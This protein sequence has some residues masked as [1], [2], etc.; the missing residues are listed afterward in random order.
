MRRTENSAAPSP[1]PGAASLT[2]DGRR[3]TEA[4]AATLASVDDRPRWSY[5]PER[6][7]A[8]FSLQQPKDPR[9]SIWKVNED[10]AKL[11]R[12][13]EKLLGRDLVRTLPDELKW[14]AVTHKSFDNGRRGFN[15][16]LAFYGRMMV[17]LETTRSIMGSPAAGSNQ[18]A[19]DPYG[20]EPF[21]HP[22][23]DNV[24]KLNALQPHHFAN[25]DKISQLA[26]E[27]GLPGVV[28]WKPRMQANL[29]LL[30]GK[31]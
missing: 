2:F 9:R 15:T 7:K 22:A 19:L 26:K 24:D 11:D 4:A 30:A 16:R 18:E 29:R 13:Y 25:P 28:R 3:A 10:P 27:V 21:S 20:R 8:P 17:A 31:S 5:T 1:T 6:M 23:L 12:M 14:L